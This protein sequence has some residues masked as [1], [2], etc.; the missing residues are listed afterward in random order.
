MDTRKRMSALGGALAGGLLVFGGCDTAERGQNERGYGQE[1]DEERG[2]GVPTTP[3]EGLF[4]ERPETV[5][6]AER[7][8]LEP[9]PE[10][11]IE[12]PYLAPDPM[13]EEPLRLQPGQEGAP[14]PGIQ[15]GQQG[16]GPGVQPEGQ[17][18]QSPPMEDQGSDQPTTPGE[19]QG[20]P[21]A[22]DASFDFDARDTN[23]DGVLSEDEVDA[24]SRDWDKNGDGVISRDEVPR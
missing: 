16:Q 21:D 19:T 2:V 4:E 20:Q 24:T 1:M 6:T 22:P 8:T 5:D 9:A 11:A 15:E 3:D 13:G 18:G 23:G 12:E 10:G 17:Q 14:Q 7:D